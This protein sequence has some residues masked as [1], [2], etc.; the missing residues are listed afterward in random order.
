MMRNE[1][2]IMNLILNAAR[3]S[4]QVENGG[5]DAAGEN[6]QKQFGEGN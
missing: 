5:K 6:S 1:E 2:E 4:I 3:C